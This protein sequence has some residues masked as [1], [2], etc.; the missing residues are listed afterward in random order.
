MKFCIETDPKN[1][2][3]LGT[4][5][6]DPLKIDKSETIMY[7]GNGYL[8]IRACAEEKNLQEKRD[9]FVAGTFDSFDDEVTELPNL[10]D[11][12]NIKFE[13]D[14]KIFFFFF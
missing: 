4:R 1:S 11:I 3:Y 13:I 14:Q 2:W 5:K 12:L 6:F 9:M 8:G 10:P 7:Q